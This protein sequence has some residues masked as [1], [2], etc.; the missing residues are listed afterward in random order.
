VTSASL[1]DKYPI[2]KI[3]VYNLKNYL[4]N[5]G[6]RAEPFGRKEVLKFI[7]PKP[8][9]GNKYFEILIPSN[10]DLVDYAQIVT[11]ALKAIS[12]YE[13]RSLENIIPQILVLSDLFKFYISTI[14]TKIGNIP[15]KEGLPLYENINDLLIFSACAELYPEKRSFPKRLKIATDFAESCLIAPSNYGSYVANILC[16]IPS[17]ESQGVSFDEYPPLE[18]RSVIRIL[19]GFK[20]VTEAVET[21]TPDPIVKNYQQGFNANMCDALVGIIEV[22]RGNDLHIQANLSPSWSIPD[23]IITDI[24][25][26]SSSKDYLE[27]AST[28]FGEEVL[29]SVNKPLIGLALNLTRNPN[30]EEKQRTIRLITS[31]EGIGVKTVTV[32]LDETSYRKAVD[33]HKDLRF[34]SVRGSLEKIKNRWYLTNPE[35]LEIIGDLDPRR[36]NLDQNIKH[37]LARTL[38]RRTDPNLEKRI[39]SF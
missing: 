7:S 8:I 25:L 12:T 37:I 2:E 16:P 27:A 10:R 17:K 5:S 22:A 19:R 34:I 28:I 15:L 30:E 20:D 6:W 35:D 26:V 29:R 24:S 38:K 14:S 11:T 9:W 18:R 32:P 31:I 39:D 4:I 33:A 3:E 36:A 21:K 13:N 23:D 1:I